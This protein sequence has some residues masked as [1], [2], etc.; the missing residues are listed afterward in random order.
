MFAYDFFFGVAGEICEGFV[1]GY[2]FS[3]HGCGYDAVGGEF[4]DLAV[5]FFGFS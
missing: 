1:D 5:F 4:D 3:V 2:Y